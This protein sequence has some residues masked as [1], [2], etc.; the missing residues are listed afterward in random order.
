VYKLSYLTTYLPTYNYMYQRP[1]GVRGDYNYNIGYNAAVYTSTVVACLAG[2][3]RWGGALGMASLPS[4][5]QN[6]TSTVALHV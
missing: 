2:G 6:S 4:T 5:Q 1:V 3:E